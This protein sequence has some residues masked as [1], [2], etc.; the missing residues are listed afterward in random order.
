[1]EKENLNFDVV[2]LSGQRLRDKLYVKHVKQSK[3][4]TVFPDL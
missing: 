2:L 1:M 4:K 3:T